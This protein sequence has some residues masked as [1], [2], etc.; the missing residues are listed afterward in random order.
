MAPQALHEAAM[1]MPPPLQRRPAEQVPLPKL[2]GQQGWS[3]PPQA[4]QLPPMPF[5]APTQRLPGWQFAP[6]QQAEPA[7]PQLMHIPGPWPGSLQPRPALHV[8]L[9]QHRWPEPPHGS[10]IEG[11]PLLPATQVFPATQLAV[12]PKPFP[13]QAWLAAPQAVHI[14]IVQRAPAAVQV[15][16]PPMP[17]QGWLSAPQGMPMR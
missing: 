8:L 6:A 15:V 13:Q 11:M 9:G 4:M 16:P 5:I 17:Q 3:A 12:P 10:H 7:A 14:P 1:P 2:P